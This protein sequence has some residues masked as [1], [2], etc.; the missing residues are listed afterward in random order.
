MIQDLLSVNYQLEEVESKSNGNVEIAKLLVDNG[1]NV[2][3]RFD[4]ALKLAAHFGNLEMIKYLISVDAGINSYYNRILILARE[5]G[6]PDVIE[7]I[8]N[9]EEE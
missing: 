3:Y 7:F 8:E 6:H 9:Y 4:T 2:C 1:A 5:S